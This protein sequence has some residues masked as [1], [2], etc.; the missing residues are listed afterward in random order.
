MSP[1][2]GC[3]ATRGR[4]GPRAEFIEKTYVTSNIIKARRGVPIT[5]VHLRFPNDPRDKTK[6]NY[7]PSTRTFSCSLCAVWRAVPPVAIK[8]GEKP[9]GKKEESSYEP[10]RKETARAREKAREKERGVKR[11]WQKRASITSFRKIDVSTLD[12]VFPWLH[13]RFFRHGGARL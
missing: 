11:A 10:V 13:D 9:S 4:R 5:R 7:I 8:K 2:H 1:I 12:L 6:H 3:V